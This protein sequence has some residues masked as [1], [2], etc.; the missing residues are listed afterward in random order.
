MAFISS[1]DPKNFVSLLNEYKD[2][3]FENP[4]YKIFSENLQFAGAL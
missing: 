1:F 2:K 3:M 4:K